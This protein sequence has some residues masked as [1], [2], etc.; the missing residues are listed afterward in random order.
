MVGDDHDLNGAYANATPANLWGPTPVGA[1]FQPGNLGGIQNPTF[2]SHVHAYNTQ[3]INL[4]PAAA[5]AWSPKFGGFLGK[6]LPDGKTVFRTGWSKRMYQEGAQNFWAYAS[7]QGS[8]FFQQGQ[9]VPDTTGA[10]GTYKPGSLS[11]GQPLPQ[12]ALFPTTWAPNL[13]ESTLSF[14]SSFFAMNPNIRQPYVEQWNFGIERQLGAGTALEVRYVG[15]L[16]M[17]GW[18]SYNLNEVNIIENGFLTEFKNAQ[19]NLAISQAAGK[20]NSFA[21]Q[22]LAGQ[23]PLPIFAAAFG[24]TSGPLYNQFVTQL[25][26]AASGGTGA[27]GTVA[28]TLASTQSYICNMF[29]AK[30]AP[31]TQLGLGGAGTSYPINFWEANPFSTGNSVNYLDAVSHSNYHSLQVELRQRQWCGMQFNLNYTLSH[32]LVLGNVNGYQANVGGAGYITDRNFR[33]SYRPSPYDIRHII[34]A[35]GTYDLPFGKGKRFLNGNKLADEVA[36]GWTLGT[37]V[38]LQSGPPAQ[39]SGG[40]ATLNS[41]ANSGVVFAPGVTAQTIQNAVAVAR[42][43]NPWVQTINPS[44]IAPNG[45]VSSSYYTP[46]VTP[47]VLAANQYIYGPHWFNADLSVNKSIPIRESIRMTIQG[48]FLNVFNHPAFSLGNIGATSLSFGQSTSL[49]TTARRIELRAN[50]EF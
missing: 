34:H 7:N 40:Y 4:Q 9:A 11:L 31:C 44:L 28:N 8:F 19:N 20:G 49:I 12:Y 42:T 39:F 15:N 25:R 23:V 18:M 50:L 10:I 3:W 17:H 16:G 26:S 37:I 13:P 35:S 5:L 41:Q 29:G 14:N 47:G 30:L 46:N 1:I 43:G 2:N 38:V 21:N 48:Q 22:G 36:G 27:V 24:T 32:S 33:L 6:I 45:G